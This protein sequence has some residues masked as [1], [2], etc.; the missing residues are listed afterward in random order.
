[1]DIASMLVKRLPFSIPGRPLG[2]TVVLEIDLARG[3]LT[4]PP[5]NPLAALRA[6][7]APTMRSLREGLRA[8]ATDDAVVGLFVH[9]GTVP[10]SIAQAEELGGAIAAFGEHKPTLAWS[11]GFGELDSDLAAYK[12]ASFCQEIWLQPSG[13][14]GIGGV[15]LGITLLRGL[16]EKAGLDPQLS[17][18]HEYKS[19][20]EQFAGHEITQPN[21]EMMQTIANSIMDD[22]V[23]GVAER[24]GLEVQRVWDAVNT[25][26]LTPEQAKDAGLVDAV[27]YRDQA[28]AHLL[29]QWKAEATDLRFVHRWHGHRAKDVVNQV[30][31]RRRDK[32]SVVSLHGGIVTGRGR[33]PG[34]GQ[35]ETGSDVVCEQLRSATRDEKVR[36]VVIR[37]DSPGGSAVASDMVWRAVH[38]VREAGIPVVV[39]MGDL[40]ASGGYYCAMAADEICALPATL[41]GSIGVF[42]GKVVTKGL[43]EKLDLRHEAITSGGR[44]QLMHGD[45]PFTDEQWQVLDAWLDRVYDEFT[46]KAAA[47][48]DMAYDHLESLARGRVWTGR[49][50]YRLGL[51]DHLGGM[52][53]AINRACALAGIGRDRVQITAAALPGMLE[54]FRPAESSESVGAPSMAIPTTLPGAFAGA[55]T[56]TLE[57]LFGRLVSWSGLDY[58]GVLALPWTLRVQ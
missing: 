43:F 32:I 34:T 38:Q 37:I 7:N 50:A 42:G 23:E 13:Q 3:V 26:P 47:D 24:R 55:T 29:E 30:T 12:L 5:D 48:R 17:R 36:A 4:T 21:R 14:L 46:R 19:A 54:R 57:E 41:T 39:S 27:G 56:G 6:M 53:L 16:L 18:R 49:D 52:D 11:E 35:P 1:M 58:R 28:V 40:A 51:V 44:A 2:D 31:D 9:A 45:E 25:S 10:L 20:A 8:G 15:H 22:L 33:P